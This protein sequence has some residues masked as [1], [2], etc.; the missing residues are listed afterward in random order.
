ML[1][2]IPQTEDMPKGIRIVFQ[3][4]AYYTNRPRGVD[5]VGVQPAHNVAGRQSNP[6]VDG[7]G[8]TVVRFGEP[9]NSVFIA[10]NDFEGFV[11][12]PTVHDDVFQV[13]VVLLKNAAD[14][15]LDK[16]FFV[17]RRGYD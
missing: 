5:R 12:A 16:R 15:A 7:M 10:L 2:D 1:V 9:L 13:F 3:V 17:K 8:W 14:G 6:F 11:L 4:L